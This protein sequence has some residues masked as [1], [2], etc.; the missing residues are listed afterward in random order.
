MCHTL[1]RILHPDGSLY[2]RQ[3][4][5]PLMAYRIRHRILHL[6]SSHVDTGDTA[7]PSS[8][9]PPDAMAVGYPGSI[10]TPL[11]TAHKA[12][13]LGARGNA[14]TDSQATFTQS[15]GYA[16]KLHGR[17][18]AGNMGNCSIAPV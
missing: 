9:W 11:D 13:F 16:D 3:G 7:S 2:R 1:Y 12:A 18:E 10:V 14:E 6:A 5:V 4:K 8:S 17:G 15:I